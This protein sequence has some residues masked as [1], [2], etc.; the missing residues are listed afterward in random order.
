MLAT[1]DFSVAPVF[2]LDRAFFLISAMSLYMR[3][4]CILNPPHQ[5][6]TSRKDRVIDVAGDIFGVILHDASKS[7]W[8]YL[9]NNNWIF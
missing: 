9:S 1:S 4:W 3:S 7:F 8:T 6:V 2:G 5:I